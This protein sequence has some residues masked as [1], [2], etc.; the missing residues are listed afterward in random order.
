MQMERCAN[1]WKKGRPGS[2]AAKELGERTRA[3]TMGGTR[4]PIQFPPTQVH[5]SVY[6]E[7]GLQG[8]GANY[9]LFVPTPMPVSVMM[10]YICEPPSPGSE[11]KLL[12]CR[13]YREGKEYEVWVC[14]GE[15][16]GCFQHRWRS[17]NFT[18]QTSF[19]L[20]GE[21]N[22]VLGQFSHL[23]VILAGGP[24]SRPQCSCQRG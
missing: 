4:T 12:A 9:S 8:L 18:P 19:D 21:E 5:F 20:R 17:L 16:R 13:G 2:Q 24:G 23:C 6:P 1:A 10:N 7:P 22:G 14:A 15:E 11:P 3:S